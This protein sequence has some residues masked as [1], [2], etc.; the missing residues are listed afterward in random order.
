MTLAVAGALI[1]AASCDDPA[2]PP[3]GAGDPENISRVTISLTPSGGGAAVTSFI[4]DSDGTTLPKAP[5]APSAT[6]A[7]TAGVTYNG[8][9]ALLNDIDAA[10]VINITDEVTDEGNFHRFFYTITANAATP[11]DS[12]SLPTPDATRQITISNLNND[13]QAPTPQPLGTTFQVV[14]AAGA[15]TGT[16]TLNV[17]LHHFEAA[18]GTGLGTTFDTDLDVSFPVSV[19]P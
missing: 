18:K 3:A 14:V 7:L 12:I 13:T 16:T 10:H 19:A 8:T 11:R 5:N 17:Q 2:K 1:V 4:Y 6:L 9:I 15:P